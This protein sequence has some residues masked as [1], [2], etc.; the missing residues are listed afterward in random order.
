FPPPWGRSSPPSRL[1]GGAGSTAQREGVRSEA[2]LFERHLH[3]DGPEVALSASQARPRRFR[4]GEPV[5]CSSILLPEPVS[6]GGEKLHAVALRLL[7]R[8]PAELQRG[9]REGC[10]VGRRNGLRRQ[11]RAA[12]KG[13]LTLRR[14]P[15][16]DAAGRQE[17]DRGRGEDGE[18]D[19]TSKGGAR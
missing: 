2:L 5:G 16:H 11:P 18:A 12:P 17:R 8:G 13:L 19:E 9:L 6:I 7:S 10:V 4:N 1:R 14:A 15:D 3:L